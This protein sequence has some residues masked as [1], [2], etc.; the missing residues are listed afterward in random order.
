[1]KVF[2]KISGETYDKILKNF[3][4][5][6][7]VYCS[8]LHG[9]KYYAQVHRDVT[10]DDESIPEEKEIAAEDVICFYIMTASLHF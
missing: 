2:I 5:S 8:Y 6:L 3:D 7:N 4:A 1:M 10:I 9:D